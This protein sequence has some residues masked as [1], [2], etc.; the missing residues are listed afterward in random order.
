MIILQSFLILILFTPFGLFLSNENKKNL[1]YFSSQLLYGL[2][3]LS[4]IA[5]FLNFFFPLNKSLNTLVLIL[6]IIFLIKKKDIYFTKQFSLF[7]I[8]STIIITLLIYESHVY[9]P[10]AGLYHLPYIKILNEEKILFGLSNLH[11]RYGHI[12]IIQYLSAISNNIIFG[13]NGIV[14]AQALI[15]SA[16]MINFFSKIYEKNKRQK[17]DFHFFFLISAS[18]FI[19]YKMNRYSEYGNDAPSHFLFFFLIS[20]MLSLNKTKVKSIANSLVLIPFI[21]FNK[22]TLLLSIFISFILLKDTSLKEILKLKRVYFIIIFGIFWILKNIIVSGCILYPVKS[23]CN[24][25]LFWTDIKV[26][27]SVSSENEVW[28]KGWP[29]YIRSINDNDKQKVSEETYLKDLFWFPYWSQNHLKKILG[30]LLPYLTFLIILIL[31]F[32]TIKKKRKKLII[33]K[34]FLS[35]IILMFLSTLF[36]LLK[37]P[38]FRY[39]YSYIISLI[40]FIFAYFAMHY[41]FKK[42]AKKLFNI[43]IILFITIITTKNLNRIFNTNNDYNNH[44]WPK[45]YS[46]NDENQLTN[47]NIN[48]L[49]DKIILNPISGYCMYSKKICTNY[50]IEN[51]LKI[52]KIN[53]YY[54][55]YKD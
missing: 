15:A 25:S 22:I 37:V 50:K 39:G 1:D 14:Y 9:R 19:A 43:L 4:F 26:V 53:S 13:E 46:M 17:Y 30:I 34:T 52:K 33:D 49:E 24:S 42:N 23:L 12:S 48:T 8:F 45:Y 41:D 11:F 28:T 5:L 31:I 10:D 27:E 44:P 21:I 40:C 16:V 35:L 51:K 38:V 54:F 6:P 47:F 20:E 32:H 2:I 55:F 18:I 36:W 29:D 3:I 7:L